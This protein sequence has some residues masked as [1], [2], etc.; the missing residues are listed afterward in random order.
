MRPTLPD[1]A[2]GSNDNCH[3]I[4]ATSNIRK[5]RHFH[6][7]TGA[8]VYHQLVADFAGRCSESARWGLVFPEEPDDKNYGEKNASNS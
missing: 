6:T 2:T 8:R 4:S 1:W 3:Q 5:T 7:R